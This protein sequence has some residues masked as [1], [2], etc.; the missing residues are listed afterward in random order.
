MNFGNND[1]Q[2]LLNNLIFIINLKLTDKYVPLSN[3]SIYFTLKKS[4]DSL[5]KSIDLKYL[6]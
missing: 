1:T 6:L 4:T 3:P 2:R 5:K